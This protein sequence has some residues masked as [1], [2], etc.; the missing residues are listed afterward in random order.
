MNKEEISKRFDTPSQLEYN[1]LRLENDIMRR[2]IHSNEI[3]M[4]QL[5]PAIEG[6]GNKA[7]DKLDKDFPEWRKVLSKAYL[8]IERKTINL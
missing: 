4:S 1:K 3:R 7:A 5:H 8:E 6:E 2:N